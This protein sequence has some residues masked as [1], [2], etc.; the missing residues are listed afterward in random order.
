MAP[1]LGNQVNLMTVAFLRI[2]ETFEDPEMTLIEENGSVF[3]V[4]SLTSNGRVID[5]KTMRHLGDFDGRWYLGELYALESTLSMVGPH[6]F[7]IVR[8]DGVVEMR[9]YDLLRVMFEFLTPVE[10]WDYT[11][12]GEENYG[13]EAREAELALA[14]WRAERDAR[15]EAEKAER[16]ARRGRWTRRAGCAV[17]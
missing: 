6:F 9:Q 5:G 8:A 12:E 11:W 2:T 13:V 14:K 4:V 15:D 3:S 10:D 16:R 1:I 7:T 17:M